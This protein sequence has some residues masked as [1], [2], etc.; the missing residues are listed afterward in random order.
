MVGLKTCKS[1]KKKDER[2][3][4][5]SKLLDKYYSKT[6]QLQ[7][8]TQILKT[9]L[10]NTEEKLFQQ[11]AMATGEI[12]QLQEK[13]KEFEFIIQNFLDYSNSY[14]D[15]F[16]RCYYCSDCHKRVGTQHESSCLILKAE[17][18][19]DENEESCKK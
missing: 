7:E 15:D 16:D 9:Q 13:L 4:E 19:I 2:I 6:K 3:E 11:K 17:N 14:Y 18:L 8:Q 1:C 10:K 5:V 12:E